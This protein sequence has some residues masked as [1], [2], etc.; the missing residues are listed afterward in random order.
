MAKRK[1]NFRLNVVIGYLG[2]ANPETYRPPLHGMLRNIAWLHG[3]EYSISEG[4]QFSP[5]VGST[6]QTEDNSITD[7]IF[8]RST[9]S[10]QISA[11]DLRKIISGIVGKSF[12]FGVGVDVFF[13]LHKQLPQ[14]PFPS[15]YY[16]PLDY[17]YQE[18]HI[19]GEVT[20]YIAQEFLLD[21]VPPEKIADLWK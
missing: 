18:G 6:G 3:L 15:S 10:T 19:S 20:L 13:Q 16:R 21:F 14:Y 5:S 1:K 2:G 17:P 11:K 12:L 8:L 9:Q 7:L 4:H